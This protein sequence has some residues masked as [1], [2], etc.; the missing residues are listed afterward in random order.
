MHVLHG[1]ASLASNFL[2]WL[3]KHSSPLAKEPFF[4]DLFTATVCQLLPLQALQAIHG[5]L[6]K[7]CCKTCHRH[8]YVAPWR[9]DVGMNTSPLLCKYL[10]GSTSKCTETWQ[11]VRLASF[12]VSL[13][14]AFAFALAVTP[15]IAITFILSISIT[16]L[17]T[18]MNG[19]DAR[20]CVNHHAVQG[21]SES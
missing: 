20:F 21:R 11:Q 10:R 3:Y 19:P 6:Q 13:S 17:S 14:F 5:S 9:H 16:A 12:S 18:L 2:L 1:F 4:N 15:V 7:G 8:G